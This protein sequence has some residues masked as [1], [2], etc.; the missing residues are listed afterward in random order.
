MVR[1]VLWIGEIGAVVYL[2]GFMAD[3]STAKVDLYVVT[4]LVICED[5][6]CELSGG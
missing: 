2:T 5:I 3:F 4:A 1:W 6:R